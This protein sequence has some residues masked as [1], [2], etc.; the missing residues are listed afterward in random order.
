MDWTEALFKGSSTTSDL[1]KDIFG[2][3]GANADENRRTQ[4]VPNHQ[5]EGQE[6]RD[7]FPFA[8][9]DDHGGRHHSASH[10]NSGITGDLD[11]DLGF[12]TGDEM[13]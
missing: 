4:C 11:R 7:L 2:E 9:K 13:F 10:V 1:E 12:Q 8:M 6:E 5:A 3:S